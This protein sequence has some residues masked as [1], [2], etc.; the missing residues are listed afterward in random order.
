[1]R[2]GDYYYT[3]VVTF[4]T[5]PSVNML[6]KRQS[7]NTTTLPFYIAFTFY[8]MSYLNVEHGRVAKRV[9]YNAFKMHIE[10]DL[11]LKWGHYNSKGE[12]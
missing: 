4:S 3:T 12:V 1:M 6:Q 11:A 8:V 9:N 5:F 2:F 10:I 7:S